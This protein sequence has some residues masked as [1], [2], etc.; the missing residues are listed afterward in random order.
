LVAIGWVGAAGAAAWAILVDDAPGRILL[1]VAA[2]VLGL[3]GLFGTVA[4]PR[5]AAD[6]TGITVRGLTG[7]RHWPWAKVTVRLVHTR[8]LGRDQPSI[9]L[10]ADPELIVFGWLDLGT[11]PVDVI[12]A[13][14][15]LRA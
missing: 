4:R 9:E 7:R 11:D 3:W 2:I 6:A 13:L 15:A 8:R 1:G 12:D 5:L 14:H 10:D